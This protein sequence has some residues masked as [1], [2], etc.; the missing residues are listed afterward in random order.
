MTRLIIVV[1]FLMAAAGG[2]TAIFSEEKARRTASLF[3]GF[4]FVTA[5]LLVYGLDKTL[6]EGSE[7]VGRATCFLAFGVAVTGGIAAMV[8]KDRDRQ[9]ISS[10]VG[11]VA[12]GVSLLLLL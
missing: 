9:T 12:L 3:V 2:L 8:Q 5:F 11:A 10:V 4:L 7:L 1:C 6:G